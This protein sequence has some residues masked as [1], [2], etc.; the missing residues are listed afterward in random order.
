MAGRGQHTPLY[1]EAFQGS[2]RFLKQRTL[3]VLCLRWSCLL[4][5]GCFQDSLEERRLRKYIVLL[6]V[7]NKSHNT[8]VW[9]PY[10]YVSVQC[11]FGMTIL[12]GT[13]LRRKT[14]SLCPKAE[15]PVLLSLKSQRSFLLTFDMKNRMGMQLFQEQDS[16]SL[17]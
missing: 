12:F 2:P 14:C 4:V 17:C 15:D 6:N 3:L 1:T 9:F 16:F 11:L 7:L 8:C 5:L 13:G 10:C